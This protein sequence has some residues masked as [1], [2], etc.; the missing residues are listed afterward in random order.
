MFDPFTTTFN[1]VDGG[2]MGGSTFGAWTLNDQGCLFYSAGDTPGDGVDTICVIATNAMGTMDTTCIIVSITELPPLTTDTLYISV[3]VDDT[4]TTCVTL[5]PGFDDGQ[6]TYSLCDGSQFGGSIYGSWSLDSL[7]CLTYLANDMPGEHVDTI[8]IIACNGSGV[9]D[10]TIVIVTI[11]E[12]V[13]CMPILEVIE[14]SLEVNA[15]TTICVD[16]EPCMDPLTTSMTSCDGTTSGTTLMEYGSWHPFTSCIVYTAGDTPGAQVDTL[17]IVVCDSVANVCDTT[18]IVV[19]ITEKVPCA[20]ETETVYVTI[21]T[22]GAAFACAKLEACMD[23]TAIVYGSCS[24]LFA[25]TTDYGSWTLNEGDGCIN[26]IAGTVPGLFV[27]TLCI[28]GCDT[29]NN[30]CDTT[31]VIISITPDCPAILADDIVN[32][33]IPDCGG[34]AEYCLDIPLDQ[35]VNYTFEENGQPFNGIV[36]GCA[37]DSLFGYNY[38]L[39]PDRAWQAP[40]TW[41][42]GRS[43]V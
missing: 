7:G 6:V 42:N 29:T 38:S 31:F 23:S 3:P 35:I 27:D 36:D 17:C 2:T 40:T 12:K 4:K 19:T 43:M 1:L 10:T 34:Q 22:N 39:I 20:G 25:D 9:C 18:Y 28:I 16:L 41:T 24:G 32:I 21:P 30:V 26:Y 37:F 11:T 14:V 8:C 13:P 33:N 15:Q 5:E